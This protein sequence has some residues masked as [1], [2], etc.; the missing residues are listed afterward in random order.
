MA[1]PAEL[2]LPLP[3]DARVWL[4]FL[5]MGLINNLVPFSLIVWGQVYI[6]SGLAAILNATTP[7]FTVIVAGLLLPDERF[8]PAKL[9]GVVLG[10]AG[11]AVMIGPAALEGLGDNLLAQL[12]VLGAALSYAF[13]G[14]FGRR[15]KTLGLNPVT[16]A[17]GQV[18]AS[19]LILLPIVLLFELPLDTGSLTTTGVAAIVA[20]GLLSTAV[21]Y[22][23][24]F[25]ILA[26]AGA[27]NL[28]LVT[29]LIPISA[30]LLG[31]TVLGERLAI[32]H[33]AGMARIGLGLAAIDGRPLDRLRH[34]NRLG[35]R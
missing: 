4:A 20:L 6:A 23:L 32:E 19:T 14:V 30:I 8:T 26:S 34:H 24:Y 16:T 21:A 10:F 22:I 18:S 1:G 5:V 2:R 29:F 13:A 3:T 33:F 9:V 7:M 11:V 17:A 15:F 35:G 31:A 28:L 12:A 27:T 25:R